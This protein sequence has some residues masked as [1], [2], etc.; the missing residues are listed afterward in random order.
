MTHGGF[1]GSPVEKLHLDKNDLECFPDVSDMPKLVTLGLE[2]NDLSRCA[3]QTT[4]QN[5]K[6]VNL[7]IRV[8]GLSNLTDILTLKPKVQAIVAQFNLQNAFP[9]HFPALTR[10]LQMANN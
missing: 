9:S 10:H 3:S 8:V 5:E 1:L 2:Y 6:L 7:A 4:N